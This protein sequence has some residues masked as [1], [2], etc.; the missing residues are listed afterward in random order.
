MMSGTP[1]SERKQVSLKHV[2][3]GESHYGSI[4]DFGLIGALEAAGLGPVE[5]AARTSQPAFGHEFLEVDTDWR[6]SH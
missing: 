5:N 2:S 3:T 6:E 4:T 1:I